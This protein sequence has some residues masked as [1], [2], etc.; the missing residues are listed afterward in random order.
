MRALILAG[1]QALRLRPLTDDRP[2]PLVAVNGKPIAEWQLDWLIDAVDLKRATFLCGHSWTRLKE[3]FGAG[4]R[5]V[6]I[7]Y[8]VEETPLGTGG[9]LRKAVLEGKFGDEQV[10]VMNG[11]IITDLHVGEM[12]SAHISADRHPVI[13]M[14]LVPFKSRFGI[15]R[16]DHHNRVL[17]FEEKPEFPDTWINGGIYVADPKRLLSHLPEKGDV[18]RE[19]FPGLADSGEVMAF[20]YQGFWSLVDTIKDLRDVESELKAR[21]GLAG[22][23]P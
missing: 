19:T 16:I 17:G 7:D 15:V 18:E 12:V 21:G 22:R 13:T 11:D 8:S 9:A 20:P 1:G 23:R 2:K 10:L 6:E 4:Y 3:H 5:G 14:L